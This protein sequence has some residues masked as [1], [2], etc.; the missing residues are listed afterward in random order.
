MK[1]RRRVFYYVQ[2]WESDRHFW[3]NRGDW[4][5]P[6]ENDERRITFQIGG[7]VKHVGRGAASSQKS[8]RNL[9]AAMRC[10]RRLAQLGGSPLISRSVISSR[11]GE[12]R[13]TWTDFS[14]A[15][16]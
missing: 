12:K 9:R 5:E 8:C 7:D 6:V 3:W 11:G 13:R 1:R 16:A 4:R 15:V 10:A 14:L 2:N